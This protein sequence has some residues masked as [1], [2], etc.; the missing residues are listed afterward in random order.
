[1]ARKKPT[2]KIQK[3]DINSAIK[4]FEAAMT[5]KVEKEAVNFLTKI[6]KKLN[7]SQA[8]HKVTTR[9]NI[10]KRLQ[11]KIAKQKVVK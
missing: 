1:M 9:W 3:K 10:E 8:L 11:A 4:F 5:L 2:P 6:Y 7:R